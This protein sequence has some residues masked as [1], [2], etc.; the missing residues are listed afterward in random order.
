MLKKVFNSKIILVLLLLI[1]FNLSSNAIRRYKADRQHDQLFIL[2]NRLGPPYNKL[3]LMWICCVHEVQLFGDLPSDKDKE[4]LQAEISKLY[5]D[6]V[7]KGVTC[8]VGII[9]IEKH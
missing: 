7:A 9:N 3:E 1:A 8:N 6:D 4:V 2:C 5:G